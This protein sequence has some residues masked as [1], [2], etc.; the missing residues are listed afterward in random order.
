ME[1]VCQPSSIMF[2]TITFL[3]NIKYTMILSEEESHVRKTVFV[4]FYSKDFQN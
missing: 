2:N 3:Q 4:F 1:D